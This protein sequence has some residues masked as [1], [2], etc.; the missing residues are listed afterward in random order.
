MAGRRVF[1]YTTDLELIAEIR[2]SEVPRVGECVVLTEH[3]DEKISDDHRYAWWVES[4]GWH[5]VDGGGDVLFPHVYCY[6]RMD[7]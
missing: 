2:C 6:A 3:S 1:L 4:I 5:Q 7:A